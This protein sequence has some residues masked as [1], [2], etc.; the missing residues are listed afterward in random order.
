MAPIA[1]GRPA[2]TIE[3]MAFRHVSHTALKVGLVL[4]TLNQKSGWKERLPDG[5][6]ELTER[7]LLAA[8]VFGYGRHAI[9]LAKQSWA[10]RLSERS[11]K[12][13]PGV[14]EGIGRRKLFMESHVLAAIKGGANQVLV[15]GAGFDTLC[16]RLAPRFPQVKFLE[17]DR[18]A[19]SFAKEKGVSEVGK[20]ENMTLLAADLATR[21]LS[22][23][24]SGADCWNTD[25]RSVGVA[26]GLFIYLREEDVRSLFQEISYCTGPDSQVAFSY[27]IAINRY[28]F[29]RAILRLLGEPW[30]SSSASTDLPQYVGSGWSVVDSPPP[31]PESSLEGFAVVL[32]TLKDI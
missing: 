9:A 11:E 16:L 27:G 22:E 12:R 8:N 7:L 28:P 1:K 4:I 26:E 17:I 13:I 23:V 10:V 20:P 21:P 32:K 15:L 31:T 19:T 2:S 14:F 18:P 5:L 24:L 6:A 30:L 25:A 29:T 3:F